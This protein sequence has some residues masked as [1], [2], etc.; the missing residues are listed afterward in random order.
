MDKTGIGSM[1]QRRGM[2]KTT[3]AFGL[4]AQGIFSFSVPS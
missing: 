3:T 2:K 1:V 4:L